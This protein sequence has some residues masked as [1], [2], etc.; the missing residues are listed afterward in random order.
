[1]NSL[2]N[3]IRFVLCVLILS[4][5]ALRAAPIKLDYLK[6]GS[7]TYSNVTVIRV[8]DTDVYFSHEKGVANVKLKY[9]EP[10]L[11]K[12]FDY[13]AEAAKEAERQQ[14]R[15]DTLFQ[16]VLASKLAANAEKN[17][18]ATTNSEETLSDPVSDRSLLGKSGFD[19]QGVKWLGEK[20]NAKGKFMLIYFWAPWSAPCRKMI[21]E[22]NGLQK[23]FAENLQVVGMVSETQSEIE[24]ITDPK[25][26]FP[27]AIDARGRLRVAAG[28]TSIPYALLLDPKGIVRYQGHP[29]ALSEKRLQGVLAKASE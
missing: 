29:A 20:P 28:A 23:R 4:G 27:S 17:A 12:K 19:L 2:A 16:G 10:D 9:L 6:A 14:N 25:M 15:E 26:D 13:D 24:A 1:M 8:T 21:P 5:S 3:S 11:Q 18:R 22:L 7:Q